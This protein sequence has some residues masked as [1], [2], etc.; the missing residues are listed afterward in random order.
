[1]KL[2]G[3]G[4][5]SDEFPQFDAGPLDLSGSWCNRR[6]GA[7]FNPLSLSFPSKRIKE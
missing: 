4:I 6:M 5:N 1:M 3:S 7:S 2:R